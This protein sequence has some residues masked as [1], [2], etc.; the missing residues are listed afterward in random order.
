[1]YNYNLLLFFHVENTYLYITV[2]QTKY[3]R[4]LI[5][6]KLK[7]NSIN[8]HTEERKNEVQTASF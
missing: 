5:K 4:L 3:F 6:N 8:R 2:T 1:M 7:I